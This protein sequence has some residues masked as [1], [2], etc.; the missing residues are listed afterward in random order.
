MVP[1]VYVKRL[2]VLARFLTE[3]ADQILGFVSLI[4]LLYLVKTH[5]DLMHGL[6]V[7]VVGIAVELEGADGTH[8]RLAGGV[9]LE[10][11]AGAVLHQKGG[12]GERHVAVHAFVWLVAERFCVVNGTRTQSAALVQSRT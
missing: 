9:L 7:S 1:L 5:V 3:V 4:K 6:K 2:L 10:R 8:P 12:H 11:V